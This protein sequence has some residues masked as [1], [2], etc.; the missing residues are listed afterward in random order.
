MINVGH[1]PDTL[2]S[3]AAEP[4][5]SRFADIDFKVSDESSEI[6]G[7]SGALAKLSDWVGNELLAVVNGDVVNFPSWKK[8]VAFHRQRGAGITL[9]S[10]PF[11]G[12]TE[13]YTHL[14]LDAHGR[15]TNFVDKQKAGIMFSGAYLIEPEILKRLPTGKSDLRK[16]LLE[17]MAAAVNKD[18]GLFAFEEKSEWLDCGNVTAFAA[19]Q[20]ELL[21][22]FSA[23][24]PLVEA[25]M[26][27]ISPG[28]WVPRE[29]KAAGMKFTPPAVV[30]G[31]ESD[32]IR[33]GLSSAGPCF[34]GLAAP[35]ARLQE[36]KNVLVFS[37]HL[38]KL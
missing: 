1:A 38:Q 24:R 15:I 13:P 11:D 14:K 12:G 20:F 19:A 21:K 32:W 35:Q 18:P 37:E 16:T 31:L 8:M 36:W 4:A 30:C 17:P 6:L 27:E 34:A 22:R 26:K 29:W 2:R 25:T 5:L 33:S 3:A 23:A 10:R 9:H 28:C 7:S